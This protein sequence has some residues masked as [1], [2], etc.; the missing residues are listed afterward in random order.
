MSFVKK[1]INEIKDKITG[2]K[3]PEVCVDW[4]WN[5]GRC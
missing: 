2:K 4:G 5:K 3:K 1:K